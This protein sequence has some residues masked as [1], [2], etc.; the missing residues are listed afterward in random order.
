MLLWCEYTQCLEALAG[1]AALTQTGEGFFRQG[2]EIQTE[3]QL[4]P[5]PCKISITQRSIR[6]IPVSSPG[7]VD[8]AGD[9]TNVKLGSLFGSLKRDLD[10]NLLLTFFND[11]VCWCETDIKVY[12]TSNVYKSKAASVNPLKSLTFNEVTEHEGMEV[13]MLSEYWKRNWE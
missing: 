3:L 1:K 13:S 6:R 5:K 9:L 4:E 7:A 11:P 12:C 10:E 2:W 8:E